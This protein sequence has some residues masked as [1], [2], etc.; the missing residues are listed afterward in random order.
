MIA[1]DTSALVAIALREA[2]ADPFLAAIA[3][4]TCCVAAPTLLE[5]H[6]VLSRSTHGQS[7]T[8]IETFESKYN[9][10]VIAFDRSMA[11]IARNAFDRFGRGRHPAK[12]NFGDCISYAL[13]KARDLPLLYKGADFALTDIRPAY[14]A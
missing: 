12:L 11:S 8:F 7:G 3:V 1:I 10:K 2:E 4:S 5:V 6:M 14:R 13:A 9:V